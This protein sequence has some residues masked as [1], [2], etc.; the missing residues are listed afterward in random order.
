MKHH[1]IDEYST[2]NGFL[3][4]LDPRTKLFVFV[5]Y[6][7]CINSARN[8]GSIALIFYAML[9]LVLIVLAKIPLHALGKKIAS[10]LP[11]LILIS[12]SLFFLGQ[13]SFAAFLTIAGK[14]ILS[15]VAV[16][17]LVSTTAFHS[18]M[19]ALHFFKIPALFILIFSFMYRYF[20][21]MTEEFMQAKMAKDSRTV[22][23]NH[24]FHTKANANMMGVLFL[25]A[26]EKSERVYQAMQARG[27]DGTIHPVSF[28][29]FSKRDYLFTGLSL[30]FMLLVTIIERVL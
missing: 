29:T 21:I 17:L 15:V 11:F 12:F 3:Q 26:F 5:L 23:G 24:W 1:F 14:S 7:F 9:L 16:M 20:F 13:K 30:I 8:N 28:F 27:F 22:G 19:K 2:L 25:N 18:L 4:Q 6:V 10:V